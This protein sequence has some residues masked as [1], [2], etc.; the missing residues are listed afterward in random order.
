MRQTITRQLPLVP[1][2][3][4]YDRA[5][6]LAEIDE[7]LRAHPEWAAWV[8]AD[9]VRGVSAHQ[10][11]AGMAGDR[12]IRVILLKEILGLTYRDQAFHLADSATFRQFVGLGW[13]ERAPKK[14]ALQDNVAKVRPETIGRV[15]Q[16]FLR[17]KEAREHESGEKVRVDCTVTKTNI[18][19]PSDSSL[20]W[21]SIRVLTRFMSRASLCGVTFENRRKKAKK[22]HTKIYWMKGAKRNPTYRE[23]L[24]IADQ[25]AEDSARVAE[26]LRAWRGWDGDWAVRIERD[27]IVE[28]LDHYT[29]LLHR[30]IDQTRRRVIEGE[31]V[32]AA[33][34]LLSIFEPHTDIICKGRDTQFGHKLTLTAGASGL[35][36]DCV[37]EGGN[38]GDVTLAV[39]QIERQKDLYG[40]APKQVAFDGGFTSR[41]NLEKIKALGTERCAFSKGKGLTPEE[42][43]G[44]R[45]TYGRLKNFRAGVEAS[46]SLLKRKFGLRRCTSKGWEGFKRYVWS[47][48]MA[49]NFV[50]L[51]RLRLTG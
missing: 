16:A 44:S 4:Q 22:K 5:Q 15:I 45:R 27:K 21:D 41:E 24:E 47:A 12:V 48:V 2:Y 7:L 9:L 13:G 43:A 33:E 19:F 42:M 49:A 11:R 35:I 37:I 25:V 30:V 8:H 17:S 50:G 23:F 26:E 46:I 40:V 32:P 31:K 36:L 3:I 18:H 20:L 29:G 51:A 39:R 28:Q 6:E 14:S 38:P 1:D 10:G 34:K